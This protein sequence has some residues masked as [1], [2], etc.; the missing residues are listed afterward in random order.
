MQVIANAKV[1]C[2]PIY[3]LEYEH[4]P[5]PMLEEDCSQI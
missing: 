3:K 5:T 1:L 4:S 2:S